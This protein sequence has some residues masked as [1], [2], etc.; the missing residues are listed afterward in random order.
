MLFKKKDESTT[1]TNQE[2]KEASTD[3][4]TVELSA[5]E[6]GTND[7]NAKNNHFALRLLT[8]IV[9]ISCVVFACYCLFSRIIDGT[10]NKNNENSYITLSNKSATETK[11]ILSA[12]GKDKQKQASDYAI[13]GTKFF[14]SENKI[15]PTSIENKTF[16]N[17]S[18]YDNFALYN[19]TNKTMKELST[20]ISSK[21]SFI[22]LS[23][24]SEGDFFIYP[25][26]DSGTFSTDEDYN[27]YSLHQKDSVNTTVYSLP[28][29][30]GE[31]KKITF[32]N[33]S[34]SPYSMITVKK[35]GNTLP[36]G[37][38]DF[39]LFYQTYDETTKNEKAPSDESITKLKSIASAIESETNYKVYTATSLSEALSI[40]STLSLVLSDKD[41]ST[42][43]TSLYT[44]GNSTAYQTSLL[45]DTE[46]KGYDKIPEIRESV[47]YLDKAGE[48]Y[49]G[50]TGNDSYQN[51]TEHIGKEAYLINDEK[52]DILNLLSSL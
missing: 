27:F 45:E 7:S 23:K 8:G 38:Y 30:T 20:N 11:T 15:T 28:D 6:V 47:G 35:C 16:F 52:D 49:Y 2:V 4:T 24:V 43:I 12:F 41:I 5:S 33:N 37:Y 25:Y 42:P 13:V 19:M 51:N 50:V 29:N 10:T 22:D 21:Q 18:T 1:D 31:R 36:S 40:K 17:E 34:N 32:R 9:A 14:I 26:K 39:V 48:S 3:T 46:L 44:L